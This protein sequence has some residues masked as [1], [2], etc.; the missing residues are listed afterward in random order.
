MVPLVA[1][2]VLALVPATAAAKSC[3]Y[4]DSAPSRSTVSRA[5]SA[6][7]CLVNIERRK[8][9]LPSLKSDAKLRRAAA[10]HSRDM[11]RRRYFDHTTPSGKTPGDRARAAGYNWS[12]V[13]ENIAWGGGRFA[14]PRSIVRMWMNSPGHKANIL[15]SSYRDAGSGVAA[16]VPPGG[17]G[18]TYTLLFGAR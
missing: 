12:T 10:G 15:G 3:S 4:A 13:G 18:G 17:D 16:G 8:R 2:L 11:V 7:L 9:G 1:A 5:Q 6:T 14:T